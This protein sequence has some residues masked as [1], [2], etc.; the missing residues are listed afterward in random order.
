M[1]NVVKEV[2]LIIKEIESHLKDGRK[3]EMLR[4][5]IKTVILGEP[6]VG[7]SSLFNLLCKRPAAIVTPIEGTTRDILE[8]VLN[9][10][11]YPLILADT[12]GLRPE[13]NDTIEREGIRRTLNVGKDADLII[14]TVD[15][16]KWFKSNHK[17]NIV[18]YLKEYIRQLGLEDLLNNGANTIDNI[19]TKEYIIVFNKSDLMETHS[20]PKI[21]FLSCATEEGIESFLKNLGGK[22]KIL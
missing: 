17:D 8:V 21:N 9:I 18:N 3:G 20:I 4:T 7:K 22:L 13:T 6:N 16:F 10:Q 1:H 2:N 14:L 15:C 11:G 19:M 12:A 5:G